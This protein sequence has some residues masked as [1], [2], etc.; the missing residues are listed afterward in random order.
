MASVFKI[1]DRVEVPYE[2]EWY[3]GQVVSVDAASGLAGVQCDADAAGLITQ[4]PFPSLRS[5]AGAEQQVDP[6]RITITRLR[7]PTGET[8]LVCPLCE[9][10][11]D[12]EEGETKLLH[13]VATDHGKAW[14]SA[15]GQHGD[16]EHLDM[17]H[18]ASAGGSH[19][20]CEEVTRRM[21]V[22]SIGSFCGVKFTIQRLGLG[23]AHMPFDWIRTRSSGVIHFLQ[24]DFAG[25]FS[26]ASQCRVQS[27]GLRV[28]RSKQHSFWHDD[29]SQAEVREKL[30][31]RV[32]RFRALRSDSCKDL[33]CIRSAASTDELSEV[34]NLHSALQSWFGLTRRVLLVVIID[35]QE[36]HIGPFFVEGLPSVV[37]YGQPIA[38]ETAMM[39][40]RA[41]ETVVSSSLD[42]ALQA[43]DGAFPSVGNTFKKAS[44]LLDCGLIHHC[45]GGFS[46][47][48]EGLRCYE[49]APGKKHF[50]LTVCDAA[51]LPDSRSNG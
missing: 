24:N 34:E 3:A 37:L 17:L 9:K 33:L 14:S 15:D 6:S 2:G 31:R 20:C 22:V 39:E 38:D 44:D 4:A 13:H 48:Y 30:L 21:Q 26:V 12:E 1:G 46:S 40:G 10:Q 41:F 50:D 7:L 27:A 51:S 16:S 11:F 49:E 29:I 8:R 47:G 19:P 43:S 18:Q 23:A 28:Y 32:D 42:L 5:P 25:F 35:G 36:K 45:D